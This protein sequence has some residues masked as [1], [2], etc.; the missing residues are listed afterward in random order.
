[1]RELRPDLVLAYTLKPVLYGLLAARA[2]GTARRFAMLTGLG[3]TFL[4]QERWQRRILRRGVALG[5]RTA[6]AGASGLFVHNPDDLR[7]L[8]EAGALPR[9]VATTIV[10][11]SGVDLA[12]YSPAPLPPGPPV[13]LFVGRLLREKGFEDFVELARRVRRDHPQIRFRAVGWVDPNPASVGH[14][15]VARWVD[16]GTIEYIGEVAD[17]RPH[18]AA[19]HVLV[20][21]SYREGTPRSVL[22]AMAMG[23]P[24]IVTDVPGCRETIEDSVHGFLVP[25]R[26]PGALTNAARCFVERPE[27]ISEFGARARLRVEQLYDATSVAKTM[28]DAMAP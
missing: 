5:L 11:G 25:V 10:R 12:H 27:M 6:L 3:Y 22:E 7:E 13:F 23:R 1:L 19:S 8:R 18:V 21:P 20:L 26:D 2:A 17:V 14:A 15:E 24:V 9:A 16:E 4:G 28:V